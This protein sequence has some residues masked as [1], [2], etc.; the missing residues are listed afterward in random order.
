MDIE[1]FKKEL[2]TFDLMK[3][4]IY[5]IFIFIPII[6]IYVIPY[7]FIWNEEL[8]LKKF[9]LIFSD[10]EIVKHALGYSFSVIFIMIIGIVLHE[11]IHGITFAIFAKSGFK[12]IKFGVIWKMLTPYCHCKEPLLV[13]QYMLGG[14]MPAIILGF[15]PF[16]Y[17]LLFGNI[18]W[19]IFSIFFTAAAFGDFFIIYLLKNEDKNSLVLDHPSEVGCF[20]YRKNES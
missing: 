7:Y 11:L 6:L 14:I 18:F 5:G 9:I 8:T 3:L 13:K 19:L 4:N 15:L 1:G 12:S 10:T 2:K 16:V 17:S 20:I